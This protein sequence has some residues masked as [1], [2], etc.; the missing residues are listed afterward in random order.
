MAENCCL[1]LG[2]TE[3]FAGVTAIETSPGATVTS[4]EPL[5]EPDVAFT[6]HVPP[7]FTVSMPP[8]A[9]EQVFASDE[10]HVALAV[11]SCELLLV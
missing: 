7:F 8:A 11:R 9:T 4:K 1:V 2:A 6:E 3:G 10:L 5:T